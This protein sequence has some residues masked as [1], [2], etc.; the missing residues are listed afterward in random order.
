[1]FG[2]P[3]AIKGTEVTPAFLVEIP[4]P[5]PR[6]LRVRKLKDG[7]ESDDSSGSSN[8]SSDGDDSSLSVSRGAEEKKEGFN[9]LKPQRFAGD[10][11]AEISLPSASNRNR[12]RMQS[13]G[14]TPIQ[15]KPLRSSL[16]RSRKH[17]RNDTSNLSDSSSFSEFGGRRASV[18]FSID[19]DTTSV[20]HSDSFATN[21]LASVS[22]WG[23]PA[24]SSPT[25]TFPAPSK[26]E[27][28]TKS[29]KT[30]LLDA[31]I[32]NDPTAI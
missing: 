6:S 17:S 30:H 16:S 20:G 27:K 13:P 18:T 28:K 25:T 29:E 15:P 11:G 1:M 7:E 9:R 23:Q 14:V 26:N 3:G 8:Y 21:S 24:P 5:I 10:R 12:D 22:S 19:N 2:A 4:P 31:L 32:L